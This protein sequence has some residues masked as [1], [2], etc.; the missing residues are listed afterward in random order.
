M[1]HKLEFESIIKC[2]P[3]ALYDF[4]ADT[5][6]LSLITPPGV[7]VEIIELQNEL[8]EGNRAVLKIKKGWISFTWKLVFETVDPPFLIVD[9]ATKSP[10]Q[11]FRHEHQFIPLDDQRSILKDTVT[12]SLPFGWLSLPVVWF[13]KRDMKHMFAYRHQQTI[14]LIDAKDP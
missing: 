10:F 2:T 4:H 5:T 12:F 6:N 1:E 7:K 9:V 8:K 11:R 13:I 14:E 3:Q